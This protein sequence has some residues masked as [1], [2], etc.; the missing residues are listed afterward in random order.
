[1]YI[2]KKKNLSKLTHP[3]FLNSKKLQIYNKSKLDDRWKFKTML[4]A[5]IM[6][7]EW[8]IDYY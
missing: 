6:N 8:H 1:M 3:L 2:Y 7:N 5:C 4:R